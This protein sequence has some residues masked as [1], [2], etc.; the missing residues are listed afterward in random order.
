MRAPRRHPWQ[1]HSVIPWLP[2]FSTAPNQPPP[3]LGNH[4]SGCGAP[5][6]IM[7]LINDCTAAIRLLN[8]ITGQTADLPSVAPLMSRARTGRDS[9]SV[10]KLPGPDLSETTL[11]CYTSGV[12][13]ASW[14]PGSTARGHWE[15]VSRGTVLSSAFSINGKVYFAD[16]DGLMFVDL[17]KPALRRLLRRRSLADTETVVH[18]ADDGAGR[19]LVIINRLYFKKEATGDDRDYTVEF[20]VFRLDAEARKLVPVR[21]LGKRALFLGNYCGALVVSASASAPGTIVHNGIYFQHDGHPTFFVRRLSRRNNNSLAIK[22]PKGSFLD[23]LTS[24][25]KWNGRKTIV[26]PAASIYGRV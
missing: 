20:N 8:P 10:V 21:N 13:T 11:W 7:V 14:P 1:A 12:T 5:G 16:T 17:D 18:M 24:Y 4:A 3:I 25:V 6:G 15:M 9:M 23:D 2:T 19:L 26:A 22:A